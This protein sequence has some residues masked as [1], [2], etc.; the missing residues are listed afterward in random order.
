MITVANR[1]FVEPDFAEQ[2]EHNFRHRAGN[3]DSMPGFLSFLLLRPTR[4]HDPYVVLT[5]WESREH[6]EAWTRSEA[7][8]RG[9]ARSGTLPRAAFRAP[10]QLEV[11]EIIQ[12]NG[13]PIGAGSAAAGEQQPT[14]EAASQASGGTSTDRPPHHTC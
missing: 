7:F 14:S 11:H 6:F 12:H 4:E 10:N 9:H 8:V 2:F 13:A 3:V 5:F 1:I